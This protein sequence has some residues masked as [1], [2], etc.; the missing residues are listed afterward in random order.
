LRTPR[1]NP[2]PGIVTRPWNPVFQA[3]RRLAKFPTYARQITRSQPSPSNACRTT[4]RSAR[5]IT[6]WPRTSGDTAKPTSPTPPSPSRRSTVP[7]YVPSYSI[8]HAHE[9]F[10]RQ[11]A[12]MISVR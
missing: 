11:P 6:P 3:T 8:A 9:V 12:G 2:P 5:V 1:D 4:S 10:S 7:T